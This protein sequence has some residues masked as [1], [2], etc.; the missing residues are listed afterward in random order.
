M[1]PCL[2]REYTSIPWVHVYTMCPCLYHESM[3]LPWLHAYTMSSCLYHE[4]MSILNYGWLL[5]YEWLLNYGWL[6]TLLTDSW[7]ANP[8][9]SSCWLE[10]L[11]GSM[12]AWLFS[13]SLSRRQQ[14]WCYSGLNMPRIVIQLLNCTT[15]L[16]NLTQ[17][18][19]HWLPWPCY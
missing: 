11:E 5:N 2:Y 9:Q 7:F 8:P 10:N 13:W 3:S 16:S 17:R 15:G 6:L 12:F 14:F 1:S 19:W 4:S 18:V